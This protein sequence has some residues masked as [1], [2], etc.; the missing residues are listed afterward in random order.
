MKT[1][2]L[3]IL[4]IV[5]AIPLFLLVS[6]QYYLSFQD[7]ELKKSDWVQNCVP[8]GT[9]GIVPP[10]GLFNHTH[11]FDL[12]TCSWNPTEHGLLDSWNLFTLVL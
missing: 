10:I 7:K 12:Q 9:G 1:R 8:V 11:S 4:V 5:S 6:D 2:L 3:V